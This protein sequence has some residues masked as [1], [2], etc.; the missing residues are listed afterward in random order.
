MQRGFRFGLAFLAAG[1]LAATSAVADDVKLR[2]AYVPVVGAAPVFVFHGAGWAREE[3]L[4]ISLVR[5]DAG[6]PAINAL[7]SGTIDVMAIGIAPIAVA[8]AKGLDVQ[9]VAAS[10]TGGSGFVASQPLA[11]AYAAA[12]KDVAKAFA[13]FREKNRRPV[14]IATL[15]PGGVPTVALNHWLFKLNNVARTDVSIA[16]MGID[17]VQQAVLSGAVDGGT[18]LEPAHTIVLNRDPKLSSL[19]TATQMFDDIPGVVI[20]VSGAFAK[21]HPEAVD[22]L[23]ALS[24][25]ASKFIDTNTDEAA[26]YVQPIL[27]AGLVDR[28]IL[29]RALKSDALS[30]VTDPRLIAAATERLLAYQ[31]ELGDF[32]KAPSTDGLFDFGPY[33]RMTK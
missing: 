4:D 9:V 28:A 19:L 21:T 32:Q 29:A 22:K 25:R 18:V 20:A 17:A 5:F 11:E 31:V 23:V 15:P 8:R 16:G 24:V 33:E 6:P 10:A 12:G 27:G 30:Y 14:K 2:L 7:A 13:T 1:L 3:G 26:G